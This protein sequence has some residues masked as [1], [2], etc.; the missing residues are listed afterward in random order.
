MKKITCIFLVLTLL[1]SLSGCKDAGPRHLA[2]NRIAA[3]GEITLDSAEAIAQ[4]QQAVDALAEEEKAQ[5]ANL[6]ALDR[7]RQQ[8]ELLTQVEL[9]HQLEQHI[10]DLPEL[11]DDTTLEIIKT[12]RQL[13]QDYEAIP[14]EI[15]E[16]IPHR[17]D[18]VLLS[19]RANIRGRSMVKKVP[20][21]FLADP[22]PVN[23]LYQIF[24]YTIPFEFDQ[25]TW[26]RGQ[27]SLV[28]PMVASDLGVHLDLYLVV[29]WFGP[30]LGLKAITLKADDQSYLIELPE[31]PEV[32]ELE[33]GISESII[34][35]A[36]SP[37]ILSIL[38]AMVDAQR[39]AVVYEGR[40]DSV[41]QEIPEEDLQ[42]FKEFV[43]Y[44]Q[45]STCIEK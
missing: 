2:E 11:T 38:H 41:E 31:A 4:A 22:N 37:E 21:D 27:R 18:L 15:Q 16:M 43:R 3:L 23:G 30:E 29:N 5:V 36:E 35:D 28:L 25:P 17:Q 32:L 45:I 19:Q 33:D 7:A 39:A 40:E 44:Y 12:T 13:L 26:D 10:L 34:L 14:E 24:P 9:S 20:Y 42:G 8:Y 1:F 6:A